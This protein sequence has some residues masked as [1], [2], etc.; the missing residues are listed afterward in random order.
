[1]TTGW[2]CDDIQYVQIWTHR[3]FE[4]MYPKYRGTNTHTHIRGDTQPN[5]IWDWEWQAF[6]QALNRGLCA[7][8]NPT[9]K[10][11]LH[12]V[13][14][15]IVWTVSFLCLFACTVIK[16]QWSGSIRTMIQDRENGQAGG[17][18]EGGRCVCTREKT[19]QMRERMGGEW[20]TGGEIKAQQEQQEWRTQRFRVTELGCC[21]VFWYVWACVLVLKRHMCEKA[22]YM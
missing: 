1:M 3:G 16:L 21:C 19:G 20:D 6:P 8:K 2:H 18:S 14:L 12:P 15:K 5:I 4:H 11:R 9:Q 22:T 10:L 13:V 17:E 7:D